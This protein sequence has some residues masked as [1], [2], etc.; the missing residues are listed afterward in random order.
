MEVLFAMLLFSVVAQ[1]ILQYYQT[2][3]QQQALYE[4]R[5]QAWWL[6]HGLLEQYPEPEWPLSLQGWQYH[7]LS[8]TGDNFCHIVTAVVRPPVGQEVQLSRW[9]CQ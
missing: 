1:G 2:L 4:Y 7:Y 3:V 5:R 6:A 9:W 8:E